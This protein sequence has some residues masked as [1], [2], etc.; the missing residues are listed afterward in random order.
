MIEPLANQ[1]FAQFFARDG[2]HSNLSVTQRYMKL[3]PSALDDVAAALE[4]TAAPKLR[5]VNDD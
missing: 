1:G 5:V 2:D 3:S 4:P